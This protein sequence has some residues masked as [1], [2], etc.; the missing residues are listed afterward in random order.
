MGETLKVCHEESV[1]E[2]GLGSGCGG[3]QRWSIFVNPARPL[4]TGIGP[5][6]GTGKDVDRSCCSASWKG[7]TS[8]VFV[9][10]T[11]LSTRW[12]GVLARP[13]LLCSA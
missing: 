12:R 5:G 7:M 4:V 3:G 8:C 10:R 2:V 9:C 13:E 11:M 1:D 6:G